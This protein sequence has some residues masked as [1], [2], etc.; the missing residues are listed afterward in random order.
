VSSDRRTATPISAISAISASDT[1]ISIAGRR[2]ETLVAETLV[3]GRRCVEKACAVL[4][5]PILCA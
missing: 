2:G 4:M 3:A 5:M 1:P